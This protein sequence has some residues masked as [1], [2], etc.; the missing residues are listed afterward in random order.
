MMHMFAC[1]SG[2]NLEIQMPQNRINKGL[3]FPKASKWFF[4][5]FEYILYYSLLFQIFISIQ[6]S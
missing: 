5:L 4:K 3:S 6:N 2:K 1:F